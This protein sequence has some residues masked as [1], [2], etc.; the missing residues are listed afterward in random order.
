MLFNVVFDQ[1]Q[2]RVSNN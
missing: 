1:D 2:F